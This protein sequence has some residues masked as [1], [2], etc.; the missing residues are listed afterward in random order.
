[1][2]EIEKESMIHDIHEKHGTFLLNVCYQYMNNLHDAEDVYQDA[3]I[4]VYNN[5]HK[6]DDRGALKSWLYRVFVNHSITAFRKKNRNQSNEYNEITESILISNEDDPDLTREEIG[7]LIK[8][9]P[10]GYQLVF[11][12]YAVEGYKHREIAELLEIDEST[13]KSQYHRAKQ[14]LR[15]KITKINQSAKK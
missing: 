3:M 14:W 8:Q 2:S 11:N 5:L 6:L 7:N 10:G 9:M 4:R 12:L 13:S 1:M 15:E